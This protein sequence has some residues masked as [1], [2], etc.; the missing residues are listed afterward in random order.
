[1][2]LVY[3]SA[4]HSII[5]MRVLGKSSVYVSFCWQPSHV[6]SL[7]AKSASITTNT[8]PQYTSLYY[9]PRF[10]QISH[11]QQISHQISHVISTYYNHCIS[12]KVSLDSHPMFIPFC[13][14]KSTMHILFTYLSLYIQCQR[15]KKT[16]CIIPKWAMAMASIANCEITDIP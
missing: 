4:L 16:S 12:I 3:P 8:E 9:L 15:G 6:P 13:H 1:M 2:T 7:P 14:G 11:V 10:T 5:S